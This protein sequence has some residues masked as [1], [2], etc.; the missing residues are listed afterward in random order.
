M[1]GLALPSAVQYPASSDLTAAFAAEQIDVWWPVEGVRVKNIQ[2][3][4]GL[5]QNKSVEDYQMFWQVDGG[6]Q[7]SMESNYEGY[8]HKEA[9]V[10]LSSWKWKGSGPYEV[11]I[12][13][14]DKSGAFL[15]EKNVQIWVDDASSAPPTVTQT[16]IKSTTNSAV[17]ATLAAPRV[18]VWWPV[19]GVTFSGSQPLQAVL[20]GVP[21]AEYEMFW[22]VDGG[23]PNRM[24][25]NLGNHPHKEITIDL[26][27]WNWKGSGPYRLNFFAKKNG[28]K[29][30]EQAVSISVG[31]FAMPSESLL[32]PPV[33]SQQVV[34][35]IQPNVNSS[36]P[37]VGA[38]FYLNPNSDAKRQADAWRA[39]RPA[40]AR[41]IEKIAGQGESFWM[42]GWN[43]DVKKDVAN[44]VAAAEG[45]GA[46]P[47]FVAYNIPS[48]DCGSYS[49]GGVNSPDA[50][51]TWIRQMADGIGGHKAVVILEPDALASMECLS[52]DQKE[53]RMQLLADAVSVMKAK[54]NV[55]VY[56]DAGHSAW[57]P[58]AEM[59]NR[60]RR[61]GIEKANGFALNISNFRWDSE[62]IA[63]GEKISQETGGKH[64][65]IDSSRN[66]Q[67]P[68]PSGEWCNPWGR[69]LGKAP[70]TA[71]G[72][73]L[74]DAYLWVKGPGGSDGSCNGAPSAGLWYPDYA[75]SLAQRAPW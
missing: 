72:N 12:S 11:K 53:A 68:D 32:A 26:A 44:L 21:V 59:A 6:Q 58:V 15:G 66:G 31:S 54:G 39:S 47:V 63:Y 7:N 2:P 48:R 16:E 4:K 3:F 57:Q 73:A 41:T 28:E 67:G 50:Y 43:A 60:L 24:E 20:E 56:L 25:T 46:V 17:A 71:T 19:D 51:R 45:Q 35:E 75:L 10:D 34:A 29:L 42:G 5:V 61:S 23:Q 70:T 62:S 49:A 37:L 22:Q 9:A 74:V 33:S 1:I 65:V 69:G 40:D 36:N 14:K 18:N 64:F 13:A 27:G 8:P 52:S 55:A 38:R 30:A